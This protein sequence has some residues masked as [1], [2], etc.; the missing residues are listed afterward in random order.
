MILLLI[1]ILLIVLALAKPKSIRL[2]RVIWLFLIFIYSFGRSE[3]D[4]EIYEWIYKSLGTG[5]FT[6]LTSSFEPGFATVAWACS[7]AG[8]SFIAFRVLVSTFICFS[9]YRIFSD[10]TEYTA[11]AAA[12]YGIFPFFVWSAAMRSG[13]ATVIVAFALNRF[14]K[15][16]FR[17]DWKTFILLGL[18]CFFHTSSLAFLVFYLFYKRDIV[19]ENGELLGVG[20]G[21]IFI[22]LFLYYTDIP[23]K[24]VRMF[25]DNVK[26]LQWFSKGDGTANLTGIIAEVAILLMIY[27]LSRSNRNYGQFLNRG[28]Y[29]SSTELNVIEVSYRLSLFALLL[30]PLMTLASPFMRIPYMMMAVL[31]PA[32]LIADPLYKDVTNRSNTESGRLDIYMR[33]IWAAILLILLVLKFYYDWPYIKDGQM[34]FSEFTQWTPVW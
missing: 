18:A 22:T 33:Y 9:L 21:I 10:Q 12:L 19:I 11:L 7:K 1:Y 32:S 17:K 2:A 30:L 34:I 29:I 5:Q 4:Y 6:I 25:T 24:V 8:L 14:I 20:G 15:N 27:F 3:G 16:D 26:V 31:I 13:V 23:Y 28:G